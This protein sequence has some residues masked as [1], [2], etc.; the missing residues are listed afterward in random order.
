MSWRLSGVGLLLVSVMAA[1]CQQF[2]LAVAERGGK[3]PLKPVQMSHD[4][5]AMEVF[6]VRFPFAQA[7]AN[8]RVW[9]DVD[10]MHLPAEVRKHLARNGFRV[11]LVGS[12]RCRRFSPGS[13]N[14]KT[15]RH[16]IYERS[17]IAWPIWS[18]SRGW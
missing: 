15:N 14:S 1:G 3:S 11:G 16:P 6:F 5:V 10:E 4:S 17:K 2:G 9:E 8:G 7:D 18:T 12:A 13:S